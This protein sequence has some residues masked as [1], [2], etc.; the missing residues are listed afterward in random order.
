MLALFVYYSISRIIVPFCQRARA[1]AYSIANEISYDTK[2]DGECAPIFVAW[3]TKPAV[4][5]CRVYLY[6]HFISMII[7]CAQLSLYLGLFETL[8]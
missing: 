4:S 6:N 5:I 8:V 1:R 7:K 3:T 2:Q